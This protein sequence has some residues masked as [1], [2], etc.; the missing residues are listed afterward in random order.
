MGAH[1]TY[2]RHWLVKSF[3]Y[4][5]VNVKCTCGFLPAGAHA[6]R[7]GVVQNDK[8]WSLYKTCTMS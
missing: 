8:I 6:A 3:K 5:N 4:D 2:M 1:D 7:Q